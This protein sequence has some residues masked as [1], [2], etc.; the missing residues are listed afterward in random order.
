MIFFSSDHHFGHSN[1]I[2][3]C[4]RPFTNCKEMDETLI[5]NWN[6]TV[7]PQDTVYYLG[8]FSLHN[9]PS[10]VLENYLTKLNG[11]I[12]FVHDNF[13]HD[14]WLDKQIK[15]SF[16][17][18]SRI[19]IIPAIQ[20]F[21]WSKNFYF[22]THF[23]LESWPASFHNSFHLHGHCHGNSRPRKNRLDVGVDS[24]NF[25]P[26]SIHEVNKKLEMINENNP[27]T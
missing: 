18:N 16:Q 13:T 19:S 9:K 8:D 3:Y 20:K 22:L 26:I 4:D 10:F 25:Y 12:I 27:R 14:K 24:N 11:Q 2:K 5:K 6:S 15:T 1:I 17:I 21:A 23:P 7:N